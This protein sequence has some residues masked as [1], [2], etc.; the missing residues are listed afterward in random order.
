MATKSNPNP[1]RLGDNGADSI[2][3]TLSLEDGLLY[4]ADGNVIERTGDDK[5]VIQENKIGAFKRQ[6]HPD[7]SVST[8]QVEPLK[9]AGEVSTPVPLPGERQ[10]QAGAG[11]SD[12][13]ADV[14]TTS[15][16]NKAK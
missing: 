13:D 15:G 3:G 5:P 2:G 14:K 8:F 6:V 16:S 10:D 1:P 12:A 11:L 4:D 9:P 7:G